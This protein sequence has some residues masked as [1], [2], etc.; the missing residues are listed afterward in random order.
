MLS[1]VKLFENLVLISH[2]INAHNPIS[3]PTCKTVDWGSSRNISSDFLPHVSG[4]NH[5]EM[6][7]PSNTGGGATHRSEQYIG[8]AER[9]MP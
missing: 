7:G 8:N 6:E 1:Q 3:F 5:G 2:A 9:G 4:H